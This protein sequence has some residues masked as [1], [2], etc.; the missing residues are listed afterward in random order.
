[1]SQIIIVYLDILTTK[2]SR[3]GLTC[4]SLGIWYQVESV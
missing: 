4:L 3:R 2:P 1:M